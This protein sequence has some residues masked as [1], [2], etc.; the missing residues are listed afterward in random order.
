MRHALVAT[1]A[2]VLLGACMSQPVS[3]DAQAKSTAQTKD[4]A[5]ASKRCY[6]TT[7]GRAPRKCPPDSRD[8]RGGSAGTQ[9]TPR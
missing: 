1:L 7:G 8:E 2:A 9:A 5:A 6:E 4:K 3:G